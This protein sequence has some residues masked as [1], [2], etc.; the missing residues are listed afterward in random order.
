M[1]KFDLFTQDTSKKRHTEPSSHAKVALS[2]AHFYICFKFLN[3]PNCF[4]KLL[5][6]IL[7]HLLLLNIN[8]SILSVLHLKSVLSLFWLISMLK[9]DFY[10]LLYHSVLHILCRSHTANNVVTLKIIIFKNKKANVC[11][12]INVWTR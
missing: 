9:S 4:G 3:F 8:S 6:F 1:S 7:F 11:R 10:Q 12:L 5:F 2:G